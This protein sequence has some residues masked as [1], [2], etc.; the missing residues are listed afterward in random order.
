MKHKTD[1]FEATSLA[2]TIIYCSH[3]IFL[4]IHYAIFLLTGTLNPQL[5][6]LD[7][8]PKR[9]I[10]TII[11]ILN[12]LLG[13]SPQHCQATAAAAAAASALKRRHPAACA[14]ATDGCPAPSKRAK[15]G[16]P[17]DISYPLLFV[18]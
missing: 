9:S 14:S 2:T 13:A 5:Q 8:R 3:V 18:A 1:P 6:D 16:M 11:H 10:N 4:R 15:Q 12:D 7:G 17:A